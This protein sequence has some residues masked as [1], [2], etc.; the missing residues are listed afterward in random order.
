VL[1]YTSF[2]ISSVYYKK[3]E[4][5]SARSYAALGFFIGKK[6]GMTHELAQLSWL[7]D[8]LLEQVGEDELM[9]LGQEMAANKGIV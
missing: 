2:G 9:R 5:D 7:L 6:L 8:P 1:A 4:F 3:N